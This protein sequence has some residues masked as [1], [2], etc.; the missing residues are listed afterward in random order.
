MHRGGGG[1][2]ALH[3]VQQR[4]GQESA[5]GHRGQ[6]ARLRDGEEV[7]VLEEHGEGEG[8]RGLFPRRP[9]PDEDLARAQ[10]RVLGRGLAVEHDLARG[11][12]LAP[13]V[14]ARMAV[15]PREVGDHGLPGRL[16]ADLL[17]VLVAVVHRA[18]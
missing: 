17:R 14:C 1:E 12:A 18:Q 11:D 15:P 8:H 4:V 10:D 16:R 7:L 3:D 2:A 13:D 5:R 9:A 6:P